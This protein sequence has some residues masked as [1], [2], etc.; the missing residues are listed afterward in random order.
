[1]Q[2]CRYGKD[3]LFKHDTAK[4]N[5]VPICRAFQRGECDRGDACKFV[6]K[7][8]PKQSEL[9]EAKLKRIMKQDDFK[10]KAKS[11][12]IFFMKQNGKGKGKGKGRGKGKGK[13]RKGKG[14]GKGK[15]G[16]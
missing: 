6:H 10:S 3:C 11:R 1:M 8:I 4:P 7:K 5:K 12:A 16:V 14:K 2:D 9:Q 13:G 15:G